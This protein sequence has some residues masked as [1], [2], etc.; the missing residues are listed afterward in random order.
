MNLPDGSYEWEPTLTRPTA[1]Q[2]A[3]D[4]ARTKIYREHE[5]LRAPSQAREHEVIVQKPGGDMVMIF[6]GKNLSVAQSLNKQNYLYRTIFG[7]VHDARDINKAM[8]LLGDINN[9][10]KAAYT[11]WN[12]VFPFTNFMRDFQEASLTQAI[13]QGSGLKVIRNYNIFSPLL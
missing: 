6:K 5:R 2:F 3:N 7:N 9:M 4:E 13:K 10:L 1:E 8:A 11:S 12:V